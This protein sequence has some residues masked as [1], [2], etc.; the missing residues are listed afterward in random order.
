MG[1]LHV[2]KGRVTPIGYKYT[3]KAAG[4]EADLYLQEGMGAEEFKAQLTKHAQRQL[5]NGYHVT[6]H[7]YEEY[8]PQ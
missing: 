6:T 2:W 7:I 3:W 1:C 8:F 5:S 4:Q